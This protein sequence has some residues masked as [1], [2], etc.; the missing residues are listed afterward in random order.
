M[1]INV[2][3]S[4]IWRIYHFWDKTLTTFLKKQWYDNVFFFA[5]IAAIGLPFSKGE[6]DS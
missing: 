3:M 4:G 2:T 1:K 5:K 6:T